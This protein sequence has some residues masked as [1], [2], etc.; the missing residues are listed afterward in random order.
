MTPPNAML[1]C[2]EGGEDEVDSFRWE[3]REN[4]AGGGNYSTEQFWHQ[5]SEWGPIPPPAPPSP[6]PQ[7]VAI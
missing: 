5:C 4:Q 2:V 6:T 3:T 1:T 7:L